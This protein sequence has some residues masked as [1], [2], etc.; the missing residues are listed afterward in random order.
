M[1]QPMHPVAL[2]IL[3]VTLIAAC[4]ETEPEVV[5]VARAVPAVAFEQNKLQEILERG[6]L[7][8]G[9]TGEYYLSRRDAE[10][11]E[12]SGFD[13]DLMTKLASD[14]GVEIEFVSTDWT[15][16]VSGL[17]AGRYDIT[18]GAS[19]TAGRARSAS[20]TIPVATTGTVA[21]IRESD[22][23]AYARWEQID[24]P[25]VVVAV[26]HGDVVEEYARDLVPDARLSVIDPPVSVYTE[27][28]A[29]RADVVLASLVDAAEHLASG[30]PLV[31]ATIQPR[32]ANFIGLLVR[33]GDAE[34]RSYA[35]AWI[36]AQECS[37]YLS[38][39]T[40]KHQLNF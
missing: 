8:V 35:D 25:D 27:V 34:L 11:G 4:A 37:G 18:T 23:Q 5:S 31:A 17:T 13:I 9:T 19:Y 15:S 7:R 1:R 29:G 40:A 10:T 22:L 14:M 36:R 32:N 6:S 39:L 38:E 20:Y 21:L 26:R 28:I 24:T 3:A 30:S 16:L 33:Q 12:R 2:T